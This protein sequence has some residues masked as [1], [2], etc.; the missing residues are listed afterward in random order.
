M[1]RASR[2]ASICVVAA[3]GL[4]GLTGCRSDP[5]VAAYVDSTSY[6]D[7]EIASIAEEFAANVPPEQ[8]ERIVRDLKDQVLHFLILGKVAGDYA[9]AKNIKMPTPDPD[10]LAEQQ[11]IP[12]GLRL[13]SILAEYS[14]ALSGLHAAARPIEPTEADRLEAYRN[15]TVGDRPLAQPYDEVKQAFNAESM[16]QSLGLRQ[17]LGEA[18]DGVDVRVNPAYDEI[19]HLPLQIESARSWLGV[20]LTGGGSMVRDAPPATEPPAGGQQQGDQQ[21]PPPQQGEQ[22]QGGQQPPPQQGGQQPPPQ[23]GEPG[24]DHG[25]HGG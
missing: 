14:A 17:M 15:T 20:D 13:T 1:L 24:P 8:R 18:L 21:Q 6:S 3:L 25:G 7:A 23:Q 9:R 4:A 22:Q 5:G 19:F 12:P 16:G 2:L 10:A 11:R